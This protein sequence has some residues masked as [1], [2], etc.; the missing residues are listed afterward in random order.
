[1]SATH[2]PAATVDRYK[3]LRPSY[4]AY[5]NRMQDL[6][7]DL[8]KQ[9]N[10]KYQ[11][12]EA[13]AKDVDSFAEKIQ[14]PG[15]FYSDP[16]NQIDDLCGCRIILYYQDDVEKVCELVRAEFDV[17]EEERSY[18]P[19]N[20]EADKFGYLSLHLITKLNK[21]RKKL[22][23]WQSYADFRAEIQIRTVIQHAWSAVSH[24]LQYKSETSVPSAL[25]RRLFRIAG[26]FE[27]ADEEFLAIRLQKEI[28]VQEA[29]AGIKDEAASVQLTFTSI[30]SFIRGWP[31]AEK[32]KSLA[33]DAGFASV[34]EDESVSFVPD[35]YEICRKTKV[36]NIAD[37][38]EA[39]NLD[40]HGTIFRRLMQSDPPIWHAENDFLIFSLLADKYKSALSKDEMLEN[41]WNSER[42]SQF[43]D[44]IYKK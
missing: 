24:A 14:R 34:E 37:L 7:A 33:I 39:V 19:A 21:V 22:T 29:E 10:I 12:V 3:K 23:E 13:R 28:L 40:E 4:E 27:L 8:L 25:R 42:A 15:K 2:D 9:H 43:L 32:A 36:A 1:M 5:A 41:G 18:Q 26:L 17:Q 30:Q 35:I 11:I 20:L 38:Q 16:F 44:V 31:D 6:L